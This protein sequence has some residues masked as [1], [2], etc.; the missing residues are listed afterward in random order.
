MMNSA[1]DK[2]VDVIFLSTVLQLKIAQGASAALRRLYGTRYTS[3]PGAATI[4]E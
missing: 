1:R 3:G 2:M 4:C